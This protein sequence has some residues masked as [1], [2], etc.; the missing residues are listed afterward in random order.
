LLAGLDHFVL[1]A[2]LVQTLRYPKQ[3][4]IALY[5]V[6]T[7]YSSGREMS[8]LS[9]DTAH[10]T[11]TPL[12]VSRGPENLERMQVEEATSSDVCS[13]IGSLPIELLDQIFAEVVA[14][15]RSSRTTLMQVS[16]LWYTAIVQQPNFWNR[17]NLS[18]ALS[19]PCIEIARQT[20]EACVTRSGK[21]DLDISL[22]IVENTGKCDCTS[23]APGEQCIQ[24]LREN[25][26]LL[27][28]L[29][30]CSEVNGNSVRTARWRH[31]RMEMDAVEHRNEWMVRVLEPFFITYATPRLRVLRI[32][33]NFDRNNLRFQDTSLLE[34]VELQY[35]TSIHIGHVDLIRKLSY[36]DA[37]PPC[38]GSKALGNLTH[39]GLNLPIR[40]SGI[41]LPVVTRLD[42]VDDENVDLVL[43]LPIL[44]R[45]KFVTIITNM[46]DFYPEFSLSQ[47]PTVKFLSLRYSATPSLEALSNPF[48]YLSALKHFLNSECDKIEILDVDPRFETAVEAVWRKLPK[49]KGWFKMGQKMGQKMEKDAAA[50]VDVSLLL[51]GKGIMTAQ[52]YMEFMHA[53]G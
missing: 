33:G 26:E 4:T 27:D 49:L 39:L 9:C 43:D 13:A 14:A 31:F 52:D 8:V 7:D 22:E 41:E 1:I 34:E 15:E 23:T 35:E 30:G 44:P 28:R 53:N 18:L 25:R 17:V 38:L 50:P 51:E 24:W 40:S 2:C 45:V 16:R 21:L 42:I 3:R 37:P 11:G 32:Q 6:I 29:A 10:H 5:N 48:N 36:T 19:E 46:D 12:A 20:V 47:Y